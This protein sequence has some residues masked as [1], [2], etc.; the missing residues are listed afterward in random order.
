VVSRIAIYVVATVTALTMK[1]QPLPDA[2]AIMVSVFRPERS[3][4]RHLI[5][6]FPLDRFH[7]ECVRRSGSSSWN[8]LFPSSSRPHHHSFYHRD[9]I[10]W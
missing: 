2:S 4:R 1:I 8:Q 3:N 5:V 7:W 10:G 9:F 6:T